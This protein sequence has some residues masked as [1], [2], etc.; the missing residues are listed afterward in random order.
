[1]ATEVNFLADISI[2]DRLNV[3]RKAVRKATEEALKQVALSSGGGPLGGVLDTVNAPQFKNPQASFNLG[4]E[5]FGQDVTIVEQNVRESLDQVEKDLSNVS[6]LIARQKAGVAPGGDDDQENMNPSNNPKN[7]DE[8]AG[9]SKETLQKEADLL[10]KKINFLKQ[11]SLARSFVDESIT[12]S[13]PALSSDPDWVEASKKLAKAEEALGQAETLLIQDHNSNANSQ[14]D[15]SQSEPQKDSPALIAGYN[16]IDSIEATIRRQRVD[17]KDRAKAMFDICIKFSDSGIAIRGGKSSPDDKEGAKLGLQGV[18]D[19][20]EALSPDEQH[21]ALKDSLRKFTRDLFRKVLQPVLVTTRNLNTDNAEPKNIE[22]SFRES[23]DENDATLRTGR[24]KVKGPVRRLDWSKFEKDIKDVKP[25]AAK[26]EKELIVLENWKQALN[27]IHR[28]MEFVFEHV[29]LERKNLCELVGNQ[30][31]GRPSNLPSNLNL[32]ALGLESCMIGGDDNGLVM[33]NLCEALA[34]T[35]IPQRLKPEEMPKLQAVAEELRRFTN[36][37]VQTLVEMNFV[38]PPPGSVDDNGTR[39]EAFSLNF[40][41]K[42]IDSRRCKILNEARNLILK[43][44]YHNTVVTGVDVHAKREKAELLRE[45]DKGMDIFELHQASISDTSSKLLALCRSVMDEAVEHAVARSE[46]DK[47]TP[48]VLLA[49]TL[50]RAARETLD[51]F[52]ALIPATHGRAIATVPRT[53]A[54]LHNDCV[55]FQYHCLW[56]GLEYKAKLP[57]VPATSNDARGTLFQQMCMFVDMVP[58]FREMA[59]KTMGDMLDTQ[60]H[61]MV[62]I[63]GKRITLLGQALKSDEILAEWSEA[64][65]ALTAGLY[66]L[67][68]LSETWV[69]IL[70]HD[71]FVRSIGHLADAL[72]T[73]YLDQVTQATDI[74]ESACH[75]VCALF[76]KATSTLEE[77]LQNDKSGSQVWNRFEA[78][79][80]FMDMTLVRQQL[81]FF[82]RMWLLNLAARFGYRTV[83]HNTFSLYPALSFPDGHSS[84][85]S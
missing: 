48:L 85:I 49:P 76:K 12:L 58:L 66:H 15:N 22:W 31:F 46:E 4:M 5:L 23:I 33:E 53:A 30:L 69:V 44:D 54:V 10:S 51:L 1:M 16:I 38:T 77:L 73:L 82:I 65:T 26:L 43:N 45:L 18:F 55:F 11:C 35:C 9:K 6:L 71:V 52:R 70:S 3:V 21:S 67:R 80:K 63:V 47:D 42:Y 19:V 59:D 60:A 56:L 83:V 27:F 79:G 34:Q 2:E 39:I 28:T 75:F 68:H 37:F 64:E 17:L 29:L 81:Q 8:T 62:D 72:F 50:Y 20:L 61:Q 74:S 41:Q 78:I 7:V 13:K 32:E 25:N 84:R 36:P 14:N 57:P 24:I 40:E